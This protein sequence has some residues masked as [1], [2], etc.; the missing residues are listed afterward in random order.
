MSTRLSLTVPD[1]HTEHRPEDSPWVLGFLSP[2]AQ[3]GPE[4]LWHLALPEKTMNEKLL[5][6]KN[7]LCY[8]VKIVNICHKFL[9]SK[10]IFLKIPHPW[11]CLNYWVLLTHITFLNLTKGVLSPFVFTSYCSLFNLQ[12]NRIHFKAI[13]SINCLATL[14][15]TFSP[16]PSPP[17]QNPFSGIWGKNYFHCEKRHK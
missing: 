2:E 8:I 7:I 3:R 9:Y 12:A 13:K 5:V 14:I 4:V 17:P 15:Y 10:Y 1:P 11:I 6:F 16:L